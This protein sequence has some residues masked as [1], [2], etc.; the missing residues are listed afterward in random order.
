MKSFF[1]T[2]LACVAGIIIAGIL[3]VFVLV[4]LIG[5]VASMGS[6]DKGIK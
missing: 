5:A 6:E 2:M 4:S 3:F 1:K